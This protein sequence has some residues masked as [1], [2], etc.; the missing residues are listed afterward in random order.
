MEPLDGNAIAGTL[1]EY[2]GSEMT[3]VIGSCAHC[4]ASGQIAELVVYVRAPGAVAR[5]RSCGSAVL[6]LTRADERLSVELT[7]YRLTAS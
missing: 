4:G 1:Y 7:G 6:V 2:F 3:T 5:C